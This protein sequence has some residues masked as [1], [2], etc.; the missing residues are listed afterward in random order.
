[1][2]RERAAVAAGV[3]LA[4]VLLVI[5]W[6]APTAWTQAPRGSATTDQPPLVVRLLGSAATLPAA[7]PP[8]TRSTPAADT[9]PRPVAAPS[10]TTRVR[11]PTPDNAA[12]QVPQAAALPAAASASAP[13]ATP[14]PVM[15]G[16]RSPAVGAAPEEPASAPLRL[17]LPRTAL[18]SRHPALDD[19]RVRSAPATV[20][21]RIARAAAATW[22]EEALGDGRVRYRRGDECV[23]STPSR[24][25][26]LDPFN[27]AAAPK[28]RGSG[29]C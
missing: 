11:P 20:E 22:T 18:P 16:P 29:P 2:A 3:L 1:M 25:G 23:V 19:G 10:A 21:A 14:A 26:S 28:A 15:A 6:Q 8:S 7:A 12:L 24:D 13:T 4:H 17:D 5:L 9:Q 27:Q